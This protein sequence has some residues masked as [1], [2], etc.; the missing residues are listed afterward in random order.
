MR[1]ISK[2]SFMRKLQELILETSHRLFDKVCL[3]IYKNNQWQR[4]TYSELFQKIDLVVPLLKAMG[5]KDGD[6]IILL[7]ENCPEAMVAFLAILMSN[8][9]AVLIDPNLPSTDLKKLIDEVDARALLISEKYLKS[10]EPSLAAKLAVR[11]IQNEFAPCS[12]YDA[13]VKADMPPSTDTDRDV[14]AILFT[15][16]TTGH[17]KGVM[18]THENFIASLIKSKVVIDLTENDRMLSILP[19]HHISPLIQNLVSLYAGST[20]TCVEKL[21]GPAIMTAM[22]MT[23]STV[24]GIVPLLLDLFLKRIEEEIAKLS[25]PKQKLVNL[26]LSGSIKTRSLTSWNL[27]FHLFSKIQKAFGGHLTRIICGGAPA[28][29]AVIAKMEG[30][31]FT[32]LEAYGLSETTGPIC[33]NRQH[34]KQLGSVG[35][36]YSDADIRILTP[37]EKNEGEIAISGPQIMKNYFRETA[38]NIKNG[39]FYTGDLGVL[40]QQGF[41]KITGR[42][43]EIITLSSGKKVIPAEVEKHYQNIDGIAELAVFGTSSIHVAIVMQEQIKNLINTQQKSRSEIQRLLEE[44]IY[45]RAS[46]LPMTFQIQRIYFIDQLPKTAMFK[47]KRSALNTWAAAQEKSEAK[48]PAPITQQQ[49]QKKPADAI[50]SW[51][52]QWIANKSNTPRHLMDPKKSFIYYGLDSLSILQLCAELE[53]TFN[54]K[55]NPTLIWSHPSIEKL[56]AH[57]IDPDSA[58]AVSQQDEDSVAFSN[59]FAREPIAI[60]GMSCRY[61]GGI[62]SPEMLW[63]LLSE[64]R[65]AITEIPSERWDNSEYYDA[66]PDIPG[67]INSKFSGFV[68]AIDYFDAGFFEIS[69]R[70]AEN[71]DPQQRLLLEVAWEALERGGI[72]PTSLADTL[73]TCYIGISTSDYG[74]LQNQAK[75]ITPYYGIGNALSAAA[76]RIGYF[77]GLKGICKAIDT[78]CSSSLVALHDACSSLQQGQTPLAIVGGVNAIFSPL[79]SISFSRSNMLAPDGKC[80]VFDQNA[81][82]YVR[83]EGCGVVILK[84][85]SDAQKDGNPILAVILGAS[86]NQDGRSNGIT[87]P[88]GEAQAQLYR[89]ALQQAGLSANQVD[90]IEAHGTGT[91]LG[92][93]IEVGSIKQ[94]Y[95][96][97][98]QTDLYIGSVKSHLGHL[99]AAAGIAGLMKAVLVLQ[100]QLIPGQIN[101]QKLN[102]L[103]EIKDSHIRIPTDNVSWADLDRKRI[104]AVSAFGFTGANV[105]VILSENKSQPLKQ[106]PKPCYLMTVSAKSINALKQRMTDLASWLSKQAT[107]LTLEELSYTLN[108]G[109]SH[110][111]HRAAFVV[112]SMDELQQVLQQTNEHSLNH[113]ESK[114]N[115]QNADEI[116]QVLTTQQLNPSQYRDKLVSLKNCYL[117]GAQIHWELLHQGESKQKVTIP[118]YPFQR[119][120]YWFRSDPV[121]VGEHETI[122]RNEM[123][124]P[125]LAHRI[126]SPALKEIVYEAEINES[127]PKLIKDHTLYNKPIVAGAV[128]LSTVISLLKTLHHASIFCIEE[129]AIFEPLI[130]ESGQKYSVQTILYPSDTDVKPFEILSCRQD[131]ADSETNWTL[132]V[133]GIIKENPDFNTSSANETIDHIKQRCPQIYSSEKLYQEAADLHLFY[134]EAF[135]GVESVWVGKDEV[136]GKLTS[137]LG[138]NKNYC[139]H[140]GVIDSCFQML[141]GY[142]SRETTTNIAIP[143]NIRRFIFDDQHGQPLWVHAKAIKTTQDLKQAEFV[144]MNAAGKIIGEISG[145]VAKEASQELLL[146]KMSHAKESDWFYELTWQPTMLPTMAT[147]Q[148][149]VGTWLIYT[150]YAEQLHELSMQLTQAGD[151][152]I[153]SHDVN[154]LIKQYLTT[155]HC[156]GIICYYGVEDHL[157]LKSFELRNNQQKLMTPMLQLLQTLLKN[158]S[159]SLPPLWLITRGS[160]LHASLSGLFKAVLLEH[161]KI[162]GRYLE[163]DEKQNAKECAQIINNELSHNADEEFVAYRQGLR[164]VARLERHEAA[165]KKRNELM[166][167][168]KKFY[169]LTMD[170][171]GLLQNLTIQPIMWPPQLDSDQVAVEVRATGLNFRDVLNV[172]GLYPGDPGE[173]GSDF[174]GI[175]TA[176]GAKVKTL[177]PGDE[178]MGFVTSGGFASHAVSYEQFVIPKPSNITFNEAATI[179]AAFLTVYL[180][181]NQ[182]TQLKKN[183]KILIHAASGGVGLAAIQLAQLAGAT[184]FAT[185][186]SDVKRQYLRK[187]GIKYIYDSRSVNFADQLL[188][189]TQ[190]AGVDVV[191]NSLSGENF[192][193]KSVSVCAK[194]ARFLEIGKRDIWTQEQ[195]AAVRND[196][197]Y[198]IIAIDELM[199]TQPDYIHRLLQELMPLFSNKQLKPLPVVRFDMA[200]AVPAFRY[201]QQAKHIGKIVIAQ[202]QSLHEL[203]ASGSYLITGGLGAIGFK[204]VEWLI[205]QGAKHLVLVNRSLP[206]TEIKN[207]ID[208]LMHQDITLITQQADVANEEQMQALF[209]QFGREFPPLKGIIHAAGVLQDDLF[210]NQDWER[211]DKVFAPKVYGAWNLHRYS[212][213]MKLDFFILFSSIASVFGSPG[214]SNYA[215]ANAFLDSLAG[216]RQNQGLPALSIN[217]GPWAEAGMAANLEGQHKSRGFT[218]IKSN[219]GMDAFATAVK[220]AISQIVIASIDWKKATKNLPPFKLLTEVCNASQ[221]ETKQNSLLSKYKETP[222]AQRPEL[223]RKALR[224]SL[225]DILGLHAEQ[226]DNNADFYEMGMDSLMA[227]QLHSLLET[228]L[229]SEALKDV[230]T[231]FEYRNVESLAAYIEEQ[232]GVPGQATT[233]TVVVQAKKTVI[234]ALPEEE[235]KKIQQYVDKLLRPSLPVKMIRKISK[236]IFFGLCRL[237]FRVDVKG[238]ENL[239]RDK[240]FI[241]CANHAS[242]LD[243]LALRFA[244]KCRVNGLIGLFAQEYFSTPILPL[245]SLISDLVPFDRTPN[246]SALQKNLKYIELCQQANRVM[247]IFPEGTRSKDG[248]LQEFKNG[249]AWFAHQT[250]LEIVPAYIKGAF[251]LMPRGSF[252]P[253]WGRMSVTFGEPTNISAEIS[254]GSALP[255]STIYQKITQKLKQAIL[256]LS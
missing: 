46:K 173:M 191:L 90:Y 120:R 178:V 98:R 61:P 71:M 95:T 194:H 27:G 72:D 116:L 114:L 218:A 108:T 126:Q 17:A 22:Q 159:A 29:P 104:A 45:E 107:H 43:K 10:F 103:I 68:S 88:N 60:V 166:I 232:L 231:I 75:N 148:K 113:S 136:L 77:L 156:K 193:E 229:G 195:M 97:D 65:S 215:A 130:I 49:T 134:G 155:T 172:L 16:G 91:P 180:A 111:N 67:K 233:T 241:I 92:D 255:E 93:P 53:S 236:L 219:Q 25:G 55:V 244:A 185:A 150:N 199:R 161:P 52:L 184:I 190:G 89:Q 121:N 34:K 96:K 105:Q 42:V 66:N 115:I 209:K 13:N 135:Q 240:S 188:L 216:Y 144:L 206:N 129:F 19:I 58:S 237:Y 157:D 18:L 57:L 186:G 31:G 40:D 225:A 251:R 26:F 153:V 235:L 62:T 94:V 239:P 78:A 86:V 39:L 189:D 28:D 187:L 9:T 211:F 254:E 238:L 35:I 222:A 8:T 210:L 74:I 252:F 59:Q 143:I 247:V 196:I 109:R 30:F 217:W 170:K 23:N 249:V 160:L 256:S 133:K 154:E 243:G 33:S 56:S 117:D 54:K 112:S 70:E 177:K 69:P 73:T 32:I 250:G 147:P 125:F 203:N 182:L 20:I 234:Q 204:L 14:A 171:R 99:E 12:G 140:P 5:I 4:I 183:E 122:F 118:T 82:G 1:L 79:T 50:A 83:S 158:S 145:F 167:Y 205:A 76:G 246:E 37:N 47:V 224:E 214:Q 248:Q 106:N 221:P 80:K 128:Y 176:V 124:H 119:Q 127:W 7:T 179:P 141:F 138:E 101:L 64:G 253:K 152:C 201:M 146:H 110:F 139:L 175:V 15:S 142:F 207:K 24:I 151:S 102:P 208:Q 100:H 192:I 123:G 169:R 11:N 163:I 200:N 85:L 213:D 220:Q 6:R 63:E 3:Q 87:A 174:S 202:P 51:M 212:L 245:M 223:L 227:L 132:H 21:D 36:P 84:R 2:G 38:E 230:A 228:H 137:H 168:N 149:S 164:H 242:Y 48:I 44:K 226:V 181:L 165:Q 131:L 197:S 162:A 81:D 198:H 41:L